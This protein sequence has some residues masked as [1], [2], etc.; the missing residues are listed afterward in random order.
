[1]IEPPRRQERQ[2]KD[3]NIFFLELFLYTTQE[4]IINGF[5]FSWRSWR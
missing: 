1:V 5:D 2:G 4:S 3:L